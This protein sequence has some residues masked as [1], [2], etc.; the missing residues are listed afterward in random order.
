MKGLTGALLQRL[1]CLSLRSP[2]DEGAAEAFC[3]L[4]LWGGVTVKLRL[5]AT[6][7]GAGVLVFS[8][9]NCLPVFLQNDISASSSADARTEGANSNG[10]SAVNSQN[11]LPAGLE[12]ASGT[13]S[14]TLP[15]SNGTGSSSGTSG[16]NQTGSQ[17]SSSGN[18]FNTYFVA[19]YILS[20]TG[21]RSPLARNISPMSLSEIDT[22]LSYFDDTSLRVF[23]EGF[24]LATMFPARGTIDRVD[25]LVQVLRLYEKRKARVILVAG[26]PF[27][28][29]M[30]AGSGVGQWC[31]MPQDDLSWAQLRNTM[32]ESYQQ[33]FAALFQSGL[34]ATWLSTQLW[35]EPMN[36]F[37][38]LG[39]VNA[40][41]HCLEQNA[42]GRRGA[43]LYLAVANQLKAKNLPLHLLMPSAYGVTWFQDYYRAGGGGRPNIHLYPPS[44]VSATNSPALVVDYVSQVKKL[45]RDHQAVVPSSLK[46]QFI[47]GEMGLAE[48]NSR[49][50]NSQ[51]PGGVVTGQAQTD[52]LRLVFAD[53][54]LKEMAPERLIWRLTDVQ[55]AEY[56]RDLSCEGT[57]GVIDNNGRLKDSLRTYLASEG[58]VI[59]SDRDRLRST[60]KEYYRTYLGRD[61]DVSGLNYY[62]G[63]LESERPLAEIASEL[64]NSPEAAIRGFYLTHLL[65]EPDAEGMAYWLKD[66]ANGQTLTQIRDNLRRSTACKV[67]CLR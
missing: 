8:F 29:W 59:T 36:E 5:I 27:P 13:G 52:Y 58:R 7:M 46:N 62:M 9:Q 20:K 26:M 12:G 54:E 22:T 56:N 57:F 48:Q 28:T 39:T 31:P 47:V 66:F 67:N 38:S 10:S 60:L 40:N 15:Q 51:R 43:E 4:S 34:D 64:Q 41:G 2:R 61:A 42:S 18:G 1:F 21:Y 53:N 50:A 19:A 14:N 33:L 24:D 35:F 55:K 45:L 25:D 30:L 16:A 63:Q 6:L 49:C 23:R 17:K 65:R 37:H 32:A 44:T 3:V 11:E